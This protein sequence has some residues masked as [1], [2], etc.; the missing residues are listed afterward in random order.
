MDFEIRNGMRSWAETH[1][2]IVSNLYTSFLESYEHIRDKYIQD[3]REWVSLCIDWTNEFEKKN[4]GRQWDGE[5]IDEVY[6]FTKQK[7]EELEN[8]Y[9]H[10]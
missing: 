3:S 10:E 5:W 9:K 8:N 1:H 4:A 2:E 7:I 6:D